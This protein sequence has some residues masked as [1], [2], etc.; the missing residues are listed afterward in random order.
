MLGGRGELYPLP[1]RAVSTKCC[2]VAAKRK[3]PVISFGCHGGSGGSGG[4][5]STTRGGSHD[6]GGGSGGGGPSRLQR[7]SVGS[8]IAARAVSVQKRDS[9]I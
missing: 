6:G 4:S 8:L 2:S 9:H 3:N 7:W 5:G 1:A